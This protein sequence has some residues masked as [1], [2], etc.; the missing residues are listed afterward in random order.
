MPIILTAAGQG[1][2]FGSA[3]PAR[4]GPARFA[5]CVAGLLGLLS[6][7]CASSPAREWAQNSPLI[8]PSAIGAPA[9]SDHDSPGRLASVDSAV[10]GGTIEN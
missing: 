3:P 8:A 9:T 2:A 10:A 7:G 1:R 5:G 6:I 4:R